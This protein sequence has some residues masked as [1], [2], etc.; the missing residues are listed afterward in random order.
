MGGQDSE[1]LL[2]MEPYTKSA[3]ITGMP[4]GTTVIYDRTIKSEHPPP[5]AGIVAGRGVG[6]TAMESWCTRDCA[7][8]LAKIRGERTVIVSLYMDIKERVV[9][10][11]LA[12]LMDMLDKKGYPIIM[13]IDSNAHSCL[14]GPTNNARGDAFEDFINRHGFAEKTWGHVQHTRLGERMALQELT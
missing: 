8:A 2:I 9:N 4:R 11:K 14:Y 5:R 12:S 1:V 7:V 13:G 3:R 6:L 10:D